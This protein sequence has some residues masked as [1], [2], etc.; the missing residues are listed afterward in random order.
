MTR[1]HKPDLFARW[2][3]RFP[4]SWTERRWNFRN[5]I[6][7][8]NEVSR[9]CYREEK[10]RRFKKK[11]STYDA[12]WKTRRQ[13]RQE[14]REAQ[15]FRRILRLENFQTERSSFF[16]RSWVKIRTKFDRISD[17]WIGCRS[18]TSQLQFFFI[19]ETYFL[20]NICHVNVLYESANC[21]STKIFRITAHLNRFHQ[22][23]GPL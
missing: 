14:G 16:K 17:N 22:P 15:L 10:M 5:T 11:P 9:K 6:T 7:D 13:D 12:V 19:N 4:G 18:E 21:L 20:P 23:V 1:R 3:A 2:W 8:G